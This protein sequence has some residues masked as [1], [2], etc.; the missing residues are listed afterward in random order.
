IQRDNWHR[1]NEKSDRR[2]SYIGTGRHRR[3]SYKA[4]QWLR[5]PAPFCSRQFLPEA[6]RQ[7]PAESI[8]HPI[9]CRRC[10]SRSCLPGY[11]RIVRR[12]HPRRPLLRRSPT[13]IRTASNEEFVLNASEFLCTIPEVIQRE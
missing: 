9:T 3:K 4:L 11:A 5:E 8:R 12:E 10:P 7:R 1:P 2:R 6:T 13:L